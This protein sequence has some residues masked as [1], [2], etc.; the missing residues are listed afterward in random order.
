M[1]ESKS[2]TFRALWTAPIAPSMNHGVIL[3]MLIRNGHVWDNCT[4]TN[5]FSLAIYLRVGLRKNGQTNYTIRNYYQMQRRILSIDWEI[6]KHQITYSKQEKTRMSLVELY[7][8]S[9]QE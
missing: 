8:I 2:F 1:F 3:K 9:K 7:P 4:D 6:L 5:S